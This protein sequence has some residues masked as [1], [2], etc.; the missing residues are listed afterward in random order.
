MH[1]RSAQTCALASSLD[2][3]TQIIL[4][5]VSSSKVKVKCHINVIAFRGTTAHIST[6]LH[7]FVSS[8]SYCVETQT[9][10]RTEGL[11]TICCFAALLAVVKNS[12][13]AQSLRKRQQ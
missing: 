10:T 11:K 4:I 2:D 5:K 1:L 13:E 7:Q 12:T 8:V 9:D 6:M 3:K